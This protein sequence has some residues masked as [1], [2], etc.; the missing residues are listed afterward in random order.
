MKNYIVQRSRMDWPNFDV[1]VSKKFCV[2]ASLP[3]NTVVDFVRLW[4]R[5]FS[6]DFRTVRHEIQ[7]M[8]LGNIK[9]IE[10]SIL[11][12]IEEFDDLRLSRAIQPDDMALF[13]DDDDW[14]APD[15]FTKLNIETRH[16][17][18]IWGSVFL[19]RYAVDTHFEKAGGPVLQKRIQDKNVYTNN[20]AVS[21]RAIL[22]CWG[23]RDYREHIVADAAEKSGKWCPT[24]VS[25]YLSIANKHPCCTVSAYVNMVSADFRADPRPFV[26]KYAF[27]LE[28]VDTPPELLWSRG[29]ISKLANLFKSSSS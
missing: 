22:E 6:I 9:A 4:D 3:E 10:E 13:I 24:I 17:G 18:V 20:Y 26:K 2:A 21:G 8:S 29:N 12:T 11:I 27:D 16:A 15:I 14:V 19:G 5:Y 25:D 7:E 28:Q 1:E 23:D